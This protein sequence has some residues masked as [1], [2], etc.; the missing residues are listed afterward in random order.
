M[1]D[2]DKWREI[3]Q[4]LGKNKFR[5][6]ATAFGVFWGIFM[7]LIIL[8]SGKGLQ[9]GVM[10]DF[11]DA[12]TNSMFLWSQSTSMAYMGFK[13]GRNFDI[14][15]SDVEYLKKN[16]SEI[17]VLSPRN[18][19]GGWQGNNN[20]IRGMKT[21]AYSV[22]GD[23]P[24]YM[25]ISPLKIEQG[26]FLTDR[27]I[28]EKR[29]ICVIGYRVYE[30][31]F[32]D[33]EE[34][35]GEYIQINGVNFSV[36]GV[37]KSPFKG[38]RG[39][40]E[41][42]AIYIPFT[43]FQKSFNY[44]EAV[45]WLSITS[46]PGIPVSTI[47]SKIVDALQMRLKIHP[48]D[49]RAFGHYN[50]EEEFNQMN[51]IF[52]GINFLAWFVGILTLVAGVIGVSNIMLVIIKERTNELGVRR[53][54]GATPSKIIG[55]IILESVFLTSIAGILGIIAGV[56]S[57]EGIDA[58]LRGGEESGSFRNPGVD[59]VVV[60]VTFIILIASGV[61]AGVLPSLKAVSMKPIDAL[62]AE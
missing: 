13:Q 23:Y 10:T 15:N 11:G 60:F 29:K 47:E 62:R 30:E 28:Q 31:L 45:G 59:F 17:Q 37:Y 39:I 44:G 35:I 42:Q 38:E 46:K 27:D 48:D 22:Y 34:S 19:L 24:Q 16:V 3:I 32:A 58:L 36:V 20:V 2:R 52:I 6:T 18:Q 40:E 50:V 43:T 61:L 54:I 55:Q 4:V 49:E 26:R 8:G 41:S 56:W 5:T 57:L 7:L 33:G 12:A 25:Q 21:G 1:F 53:A 9:N 51:S 14:R